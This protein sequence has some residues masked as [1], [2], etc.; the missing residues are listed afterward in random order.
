MAKEKKKIKIS[1]VILVLS[2]ITFAVLLMVFLKQQ[3][4]NKPKT[5]SLRE[6]YQK[7]FLN[8]GDNEK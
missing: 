1:R 8:Q 5:V 3:S 2:V 7:E 4:D 6:E